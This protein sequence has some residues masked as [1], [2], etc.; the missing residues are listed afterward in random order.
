MADYHEAVFRWPYGGQNVILTG[1]FDQWSSSIR[2]NRGPS[3]FEGTVRVPWSEKVAYKF[4]VDGTWR[5]TDEAPVEYDPIGNRNNVYYAPTRPTLPTI[6]HELPMVAVVPPSPQPPIKAPTEEK[7]VLPTVGA[8]TPVV[9]TIEQQEEPTVPAKD[10]SSNDA[11]PEL[12]DP[13]VETQVIDPTTS[14]EP[15]VAQHT[16]ADITIRADIEKPVPVPPTEPE[17]AISEGPPTPISEP[18]TAAAQA[19]SHNISMPIVPLNDSGLVTKSPVTTPDAAPEDLSLS[20]HAPVNSTRKSSGGSV[21]VPAAE[22]EKKSIAGNGSNPADTL[23]SPPTTPK[24]HRFSLHGSHSTSPNTSTRSSKFDST[25]SSTKS[26]RKSS[27][28]DKL[29]TIFSPDKEK[30]GVKK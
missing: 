3:G 21:P 13:E 19:V 28:I 7:A 24:K 9:P 12:V 11:S 4:I 27:F 1:T 25:K 22:P 6:S 8:G 29:K 26:R 5:T 14:D 2:L 18:D 15:E 30:E 10:T 23:P 20:T 17:S 16:E